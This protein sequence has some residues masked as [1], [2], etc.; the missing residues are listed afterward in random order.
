MDAEQPYPDVGKADF[1]AIEERALERWAS[2]GTFAASVDARP[3]EVEFTFNDGPPFANGLPHHG[4]LLT[5]YVK[6]VVPRYK[7]M[8]GFHVPRKAGWD[9]HGLPVEIEVEK[10]LGIFDKKDRAR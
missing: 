5:G 10:Q 6:D 7:T 1:P 9:T 2:E 3:D 8:R 4:N